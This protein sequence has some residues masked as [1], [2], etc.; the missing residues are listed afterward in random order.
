MFTIS[1]FP[2]YTDSLYTPCER[3]NTEY[4][5]VQITLFYKNMVRN[6]N[7]FDR[8]KLRRRNVLPRKN[9]SEKSPVEKCRCNVRQTS[10]QE[11]VRSIN[12]PSG[13][14]PFGKMT[15]GEL[16]VRERSIGEPSFHRY[17]IKASPKKEVLLLDELS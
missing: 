13:K 3:N 4:I 1:L 7:F 17:D 2:F 14:R 12:V 6:Q 5:K 9:P 15:V 16:S 11:K 10:V 8:G